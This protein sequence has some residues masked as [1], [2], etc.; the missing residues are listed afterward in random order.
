MPSFGK[1][2]NETQMWQVTLFL[3]HMDQLPPD[4]QAAWRNLKQ[5]VA[6]P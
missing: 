2:L 3:K 1:A 4:A 6:A 5:V